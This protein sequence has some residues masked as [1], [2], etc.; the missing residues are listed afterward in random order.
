MCQLD[1][2]NGEKV[3]RFTLEKTC[4]TWYKRLKSFGKVKLLTYLWEGHNAEVQ[5]GKK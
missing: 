2:E 5:F 4:I 3:E 1:R